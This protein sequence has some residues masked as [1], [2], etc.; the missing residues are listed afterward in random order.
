[1]AIRP[2]DAVPRAVEYV[3]QLTEPPVPASPKLRLP[4]YRDQGL[5]WA[6]T[7][8]VRF[9]GVYVRL[10][11]SG[12]GAPMRAKARRWSGVG[13]ARAGMVAWS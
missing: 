5:N 4:R 8:W 9:C 11:V 10:R 1:M 13:S 3:S 2:G 6:F 7:V 12:M